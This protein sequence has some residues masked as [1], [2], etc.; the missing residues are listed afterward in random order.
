M[1]ARQKELL[2]MAQLSLDAAEVLIDKHFY[3]YAL[4]RTYYA[5]FYVAEAFLESLKLNFAKH[6]AVISAFGRE[7]VKSGKVPKDFHRYLI[8]A[9]ELR[10]LA[11]YA[12]PTQVTQQQAND[13]FV[14]AQ[15]FLEIAYQML[16]ENTTKD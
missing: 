11:D 16:G 6:H 2:E 9:S 13:Y 15:D 1:N 4:A 5:M 12:E 10:T 14:H 3:A 8:K 7:F